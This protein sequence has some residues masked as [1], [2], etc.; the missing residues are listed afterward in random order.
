MRWS[1]PF[2][3]VLT[4]NP[5]PNPN[6]VSVHYTGIKGLLTQLGSSVVHIYILIHSHSIVDT[7][8]VRYWLGG[9]LC[10]TGLQL[11]FKSADACKFPAGTGTISYLR[12][13]PYATA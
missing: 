4:P 6:L 3:S 12:R 5:A 2:T 1:L 13:R 11:G 9:F 10:D 7:T 8:R